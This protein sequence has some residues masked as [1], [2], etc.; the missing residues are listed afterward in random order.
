MSGV[1]V[2]LNDTEEKIFLKDGVC[3]FGITA[4]NSL[5]ESGSPQTYFLLELPVKKL[6]RFVQL[7][8]QGE[9]RFV[10][11]LD[12]VVRHCLP[13]LISG[14][15]TFKANEIKLSRDAE[16]DIED[17]IS[18]T[19]LEKIKRSLRKR[20][21]A[22]PARLLFD[23]H[24]PQ[25]LLDLIQDITGVTYDEL[26]TGSR[27]HNFRDFFSFPDLNRPD[28]HYP[29]Q[30]PLPQ[31]VLEK[32][33]DL[34]KTI[35]QADQIV[36]YPYQKFDYVLKLLNQAAADPDVK[37][38]AITLY[39]VADKSA[40]GKALVKAAKNGKQVTAIIELQARFDE[41]SNITWAT[42]LEKAG[43]TVIHGVPG[44][45]VHTKLCLIH[46]EEN[47]KKKLYAYL[48]TGNFNEVTSNIYADHAIFTASA[49]ITRE[50]QEI[51][52]FFIDLKFSRRFMHL[53][54]APFN[55]RRKF[56]ELIDKEIAAAKE[57]KTAYMILKMNALE[58][59]RMVEKLYEASNA[60][61]NIRMLVRGICVLKPGVPGMSENITVTGVID[62]HLEH[63]R[64][65]IFGNGGNEKMYVASADWMTRN[66]SRRIEVAFPIYNKEAFSQIREIIELQVNDNTKARDVDNNYF[67]SSDEAEKVQSQSE[68][69]TFLKQLTKQKDTTK[70]KKQALAK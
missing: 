46:R 43:A 13:R 19:L 12:D 20:A 52:N 62:R 53:L 17:E 6:G 64:V 2:V 41:E 8:N 48:S 68:T 16:L 28:L 9:K 47:N 7:P 5:T 57:G 35:S 45:K 3:Y 22:H 56:Y 39:R 14:F 27:Y 24:I 29:K 44:H 67:T 66:L 36:H 70:A 69:Y 33:A 40:V 61:V 42:K 34:F 4:C 50:V 37:S 32:S 51:F 25:Q 60:G 54:V 38:I 11:M 58:D 1:K 31:P 49:K 23:P 63:A 26:V 65:Y 59:E 21:T 15:K 55:M 10:M 18:G 30:E